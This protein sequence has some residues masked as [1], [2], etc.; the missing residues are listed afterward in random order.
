VSRA[1]QSFHRLE[2]AESAVTIGCFDAD[3][4][5]VVEQ[6]VHEAGVLVRLDPLGEVFADLLAAFPQVLHCQRVP[7]P[8][9]ERLPVQ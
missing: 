3:H 2:D 1:P 6:P 7:E 5:P 4:D 9:L 8:W